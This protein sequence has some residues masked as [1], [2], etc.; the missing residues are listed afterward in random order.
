MIKAQTWM[1]FKWFKWFKVFIYIL[2]FVY[3]YLF[4]YTYY[5]SKQKYF[6]I[7]KNAKT[8]FYLLPPLLNLENYSRSFHYKILNHVFYLNKDLFTF[9]KLTSPVF[10]FCKL[11]DETV[12]DLSFKIYEWSSF[13]L[14]KQLCSVWSNTADCLY[15]FP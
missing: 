6:F 13:I 1:K 14:L 2:L 11:S 12:L 7:Y 5:S 3:V 15:R 9:R 10:Y 8:Y 4:Q